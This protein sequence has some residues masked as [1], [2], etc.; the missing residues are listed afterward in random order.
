MRIATATPPQSKVVN[1]I[2]T[3]NSS[4]NSDLMISENAHSETSGRSSISDTSLKFHHPIP[5]PRSETLGTSDAIERGQCA[6]VSSTPESDAPPYESTTRR[7][8]CL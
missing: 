5:A 1:W 4:P 6:M 8:C 3:P 2:A 7:E